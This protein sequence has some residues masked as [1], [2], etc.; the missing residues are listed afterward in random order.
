MAKTKRIYRRR[1]AWNSKKWRRYSKYNYFNWKFEVVGY[2][3]YPVTSGELQFNTSDSNSITFPHLFTTLDDEWAPMCKLFAYYKIRGVSVEI[4]P[5]LNNQDAAQ[6]MLYQPTFLALVNNTQISPN[7]IP[8]C[9]RSI[10]LDSINRKYT[11]WNLYNSN[12]WRATAD[13]DAYSNYK[14]VIWNGVQKTAA[15]GPAWQF[16]FKIYLTFKSNSI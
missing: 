11:Y 3:A 7:E 14:F 12:D 5:S 4:I 9:E 1:N 15:A 16:R 6:K 10:M 13:S 8:K 2:A